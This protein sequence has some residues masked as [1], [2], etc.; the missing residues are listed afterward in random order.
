MIR[1]LLIFLFIS[2]F[3]FSQSVSPTGGKR[4]WVDELGNIYIQNK[5][6][7]IKKD[8]S[9]KKSFTYQNNLHAENMD[10]DVS[11]PLRILIFYPDFNQ[12]VFLD[13]MLAEQRSPILLDELELYDISAICASPEGGFWVYNSQAF[14]L[15]HY[16]KA[17]KK[18]YT[19]PDLSSLVDENSN[20]IRLYSAD[21]KIFLVLTNESTLI[22]DQFG[23]FIKKI[24]PLQMKFHQ[25]LNEQLI[26]TKNDSLFHYHPDYLITKKYPLFFDQQF[27]DFKIS[28]SKSYFLTKDSLYIYN[29][30][31]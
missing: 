17:L 20:E 3:S 12:L 11:N 7:F 10:I 15:Q 2:T 5:K 29:S 26:Y 6:G 28:E 14:Q 31:H 8:I 27:T 25:I 18:T 24:P 22:F 30:K 13:N 21:N 23:G 19:S 16:D 9:A 1:I 4:I